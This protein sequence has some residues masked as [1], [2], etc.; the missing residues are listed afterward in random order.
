[1]TPTPGAQKEAL[2]DTARALVSLTDVVAR[3][4]DSSDISDLNNS[5]V[6]LPGSFKKVFICFQ[7]DL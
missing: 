2:I 1:L 3:S 4:L 7:I 6:E 5:I